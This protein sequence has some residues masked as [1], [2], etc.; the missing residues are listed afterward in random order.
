MV[1]P[2]MDTMKILEFLC[3]SEHLSPFI[4][5]RELITEV[6]NKVLASTGFCFNF[7]HFPFTHLAFSPNI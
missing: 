5:L 7:F 1:L 6:L 2:L 3:S 4:L